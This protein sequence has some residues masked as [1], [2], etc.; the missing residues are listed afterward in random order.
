[1]VIICFAFIEAIHHLKIPQSKT[2]TLRQMNKAKLGQGLTLKQ[3][4]FICLRIFFSVCVL[5]FFQQAVTLKFYLKCL[6]IE[7]Y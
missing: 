1:M 4:T 2:S 7:P 6:V 5:F 3:C